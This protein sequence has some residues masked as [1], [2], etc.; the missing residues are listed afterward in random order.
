MANLHFN[1]QAFVQFVLQATPSLYLTEEMSDRGKFDPIGSSWGCP[2]VTFSPDV[3]EKGQKPPEFLSFFSLAMCKPRIVC[4]TSGFSVTKGEKLLAS[5]KQVDI[6]RKTTLCLLGWS[7]SRPLGDPVILKRVLMM[8]ASLPLGRCSTIRQQMTTAAL[9]S[10]LMWAPRIH[11]PCDNDLSWPPYTSRQQGSR[12]S[13]DL[14]ITQVW[15]MES[16][17]VASITVKIVC[18]SDLNSIVNLQTNTM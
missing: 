13:N 17:S 1:A 4:I 12:P 3:P 16:T 18:L 11:Q 7:C 9:C 8:S 10:A 14:R 15:S 5:T 2:Q 6:S